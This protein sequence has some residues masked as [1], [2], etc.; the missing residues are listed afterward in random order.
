MKDFKCNYYKR[1]LF[2][3]SFFVKKEKFYGKYIDVY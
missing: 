2:R 3:G 1:I